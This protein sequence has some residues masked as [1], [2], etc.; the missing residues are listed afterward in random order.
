VTVPRLK[1]YA[2]DT[3]RVYDYSFAGKRPALAPF[4][5]AT[6]YLYD[7]SSDRRSKF[8]VSIFVLDEAVADWAARHGR[9]LDD[10]ERY[11]AAKLALQRAFDEIEDMHRSGRQLQVDSERLEELLAPLDL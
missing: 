8:A 9:T 6:E 11:A 7:V 4:G 3:G 1:T 2:S 10:N 5:A